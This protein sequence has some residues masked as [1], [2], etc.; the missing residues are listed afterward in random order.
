MT[1]HRPLG[2]LA[3]VAMVHFIIVG[4]AAPCSTPHGNVRAETP[5]HSDCAPSSSHSKGDSTDRGTEAPCCAA[6][7]SCAAA[8]VAARTI[9]SAVSAPMVTVASA[10]SERAPRAEVPAPELPPPRA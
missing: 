6:L 1:V 5:A 8:P 10:A 9:A 3:L 2:M 4:T 7:A